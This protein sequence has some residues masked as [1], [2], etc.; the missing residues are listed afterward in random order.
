MQ[1]IHSTKETEKRFEYQ[2][3]GKMLFSHGTSNSTGVCICFRYNLEHKII[4][5][6]SDAEGR[7]I[8]ANME[9]QGNPYVLVNCY[10]PNTETG[11]I[12]T[13][14][15]LAN[16]LN[17]LDADPEC[18][19][20][21]G[22]DWNLI[23]DTT[24]DSMGGSPKLKE[25][26]IFHLRSIM[27]DYELVDIYRLRNP[28]LRQFTW[29][30]KTPLTM[31]SLDFF[32]ISNTLQSE[33]KSCEHLFPL[34]SD[35]TPVKIH[36]LSSTDHK[37]GA[38]YWKFNNSLLENNNFSSEMKDKINQIV[39]E[40]SEFDDPRINWEYLKF[41]MREVARNRSIELAKERREKKN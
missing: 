40:F 13:F 22:G 24:M 23:F 11:Q 32:L 34:S 1:E 3:G 27:S 26:S 37:R 28:G 21:F 9:I 2:W 17:D 35:H 6:I 8:I 7:Y 14:Q 33:V 12:K 15:D 39:S 30:C 16:R 18:N 10:A 41:K 20:I 36:F 29:R 4:K 19:Y 31:R 38:G 5:V 25:K